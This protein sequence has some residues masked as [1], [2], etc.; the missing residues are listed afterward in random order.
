MSTNKD[1]TNA[2]MSKG[3]SE[4]AVIES[5]G[6][7]I[8]DIIEGYEFVGVGGYRARRHQIDNEDYNPCPPPSR[9]GELVFQ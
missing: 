8:D 2:V 6:R 4:Y 1:R 9:F 5:D 3:V 7:T